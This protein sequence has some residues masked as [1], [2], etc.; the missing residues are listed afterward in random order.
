MTAVGKVVFDTSSSSSPLHIMTVRH[1]RSTNNDILEDL[2]IQEMDDQITSEDRERLWLKNRVHDPDLTQTG[3]EEAIKLSQWLKNSNITTVKRLIVFTSPFKRTLDTTSGLLSLLNS[4]NYSVIVHPELYETGGVY[5]TGSKGERT[6]PGQ[7][8]SAKEIS[9]NFSDYD[10]SMLPITGQWYTK[11]WENDQESMARGT[12]IAN[13]MKSKDIRHTIAATAAPDDTRDVLVLMVMHGSIINH[14]QKAI[15]GIKENKE[16]YTTTTSNNYGKNQL[17][18]F[19]TA[20]TATS[21]FTIS[22]GQVGV[23]W[24]GSTIHLGLDSKR[25]ILSRI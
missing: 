5:S 8:L 9:T 1:G 4:K 14:I 12:R 17:V 6:G 18:N 7:C 20:N 11:G 25:T 2:F 16:L 21:L 15:L 3:K 23:Q 10:V 19:G 22:G 24:I 13:W